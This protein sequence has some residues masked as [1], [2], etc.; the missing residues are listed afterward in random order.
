MGAKQ[1][2]ICISLSSTVVV[3]LNPIHI[4]MLVSCEND[5]AH[6]MSLEAAIVSAN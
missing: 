1:S 4:G 2:T 3:Q 5:N 6:N